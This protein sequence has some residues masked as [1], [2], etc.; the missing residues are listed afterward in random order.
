MIQSETEITAPPNASAI[1]KLVLATVNAP[2]KRDITAAILAGCLA[3]AEFG[4]WPV[5]V[6]A[7]LTEVE[8]DLVLRFA[9]AHGVSRDTLAKTYL[10]MKTHT[11][12]CHPALEAELGTVGTASE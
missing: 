11:G 6:S 4:R 8:P 12:R 9:V 7:F 3:G 5:H 10:A 2:Y 1:D